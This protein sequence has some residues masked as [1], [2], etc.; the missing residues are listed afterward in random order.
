[1]TTMTTPELF[2]IGVY[3]WDDARFFQA[4]LD[5][6][7]D[8]FVDIRARRGVRGSEYTFA[9]SAR[10]QARLAELGIR[11]VHRPDLAPTKEVRERQY[12]TD[13]ANKT[14]KRQRTVLS[15]P[16]VEAYLQERLK[17]FDCPAFIDSL[18]PDA[19]RI[20]LMCVEAQP[21]ACHRLLLAERLHSVLKLEVTHL[22]P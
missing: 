7:V 11:Y 10:L 6:N 19:R 9:N 17:G 3:G 14:A 21:A 15:V 20:V 22:L 5:A 8:T 2:T 4:L 1:M 13:A 16:F 18:G 12:E